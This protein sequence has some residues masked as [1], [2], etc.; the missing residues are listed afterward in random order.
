MDVAK[1]PLQYTESVEHPYSSLSRSHHVNKN[2]T[3]TWLRCHY[4][5]TVLTTPLLRSYRVLIRP[6]PCCAFLYMLKIQ[7]R[8]SRPWRPYF[9]LFGFYYALT[10]SYNIALRPWFFFSTWG[11]SMN[12][13][14]CEGGITPPCFWWIKIIS[15][16]NLLS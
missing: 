10:T 12:V 14:E 11:R 3:T 15:E 6:G 8:P 16:I 4:V 7:P 13:V 9:Q 1:T 5:H 2:P